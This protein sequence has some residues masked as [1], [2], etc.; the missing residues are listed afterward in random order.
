MDASKV[1][2]ALVAVVGFYAEA[3]AEAGKEVS[4]VTRGALAFQSQTVAQFRLYTKLEGAARAAVAG[5]P[6]GMEALAAALAAL[7]EARGDKPN[8]HMDA[9]ASMAATPE[10]P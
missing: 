10:S 2:N 4:Q 1:S 7:D 6:T 3:L 5:G 9:R 8:W